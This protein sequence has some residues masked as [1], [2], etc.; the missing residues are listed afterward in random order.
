MSRDYNTPTDDDEQLDEQLT[1]QLREHEPTTLGEATAAL[2]DD[3]ATG[4]YDGPVGLYGPI[5]ALGAS[6]V[7][8]WI[9]VS[10]PIIG[11]RAMS[12]YDLAGWPLLGATA[13]L[14][15]VTIIEWDHRDITRILVGGLGVLLFTAYAAY[16]GSKLDQMTHVAQG[17]M[18][19]GTVSGSIGGGVP[20]AILAS[21]IAA[22]AGYKSRASNE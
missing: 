5:A 2:G 10:A 4:W 13:I 20:V 14:L 1:E 17:T 19:A 22:Y 12:G 3:D 18:F 21:A 8:P 9:K 6:M 16:L 15:A 11:Q 7:L